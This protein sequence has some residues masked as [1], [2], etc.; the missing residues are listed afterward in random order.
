MA[1]T[2]SS[3]G[4]IGTNDYNGISIGTIGRTLTDIG[5]SVPLLNILWKPWGVP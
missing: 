1:S 3:G 2:N 5:I 4:N